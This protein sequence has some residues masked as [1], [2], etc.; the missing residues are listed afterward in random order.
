MKRLLI[1]A[2]IAMIFLSP[3][4]QAQEKWLQNDG[5]NDGD[6]AFY[7]AGFIANSI[8]ASVF[9]PDPDDYP[10]KLLTVRTLVHDGGGGGTVGAF[11][12]RVWE[13]A[14]GS[15]DPGALLFEETYQLTAGGYWNDVD[16][17]PHNIIISSGNVRI[18]W[19]FVL[20]PPPSFLRDADGTI[21]P[22]RN[23][24]YS[25]WP[26]QWY[27]QWAEN[28][29]LQGDWIHRVKIMANYGE[30]TPTPDPPTPTPVPPTETPVPPTETP[31][32]PTE[33][34][35]PTNTPPPTH[36]PTIIPSST[37]D[38]PTP[39]PTSVP[40]TETPLPPT[41]T[42]IPPTETPVPPTATPYDGIIYWDQDIYYGPDARA[43]I[44][45]EDADLDTDPNVQETVE[46]RVWSHSTD[47]FP[48]GLTVTLYETAPSSPIFRTIV[49][50]VGFG[51]QTI[52]GDNIIGV[53]EGEMVYARYVDVST[54]EEKIA[55]AQW[56]SDSLHLEFVMPQTHFREGDLFW[57]D[58]HFNNPGSTVQVDMYILL[59]VYGEFFCYPTWE[60]IDHGLPYE[61]TFIPGGESG[62]MTVM[63]PFNTPDVY[64][65]GPFHFYAAMF[66]AGELTIEE[67]I[68][69]VP[70][71]E[72]YFE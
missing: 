20:D 65:M 56:Q 24:I 68:S 36:T 17:A 11:V 8:M 51:P 28:A 46:I 5:W 4:L 30:A 71:G 61:R 45:V 43:I 50:H 63:P 16:L 69:N 55:V 70:L 25:R 54:G 3:C 48:G 35:I 41:E 37:P 9:V 72:F 62:T 7:Q 15:V 1:L 33:T 67:L 64:P 58:L 59:D 13:D 40:P 38:T 6:N 52:P 32:P 18:G 47:P 66:T 26:V 60:H 14:G 42:P 39:T 57:C 12:L 10:F 49:P 27:W 23:L 31:V 53:T 2:G 29:G 19:L 44:T 21:I 34:P 22:Q